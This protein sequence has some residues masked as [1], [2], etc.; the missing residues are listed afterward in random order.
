[1]FMLGFKPGQPMKVE[2]TNRVHIW[3]RMPQFPME[4]WRDKVFEDVAKILGPRFQQ[5]NALDGWKEM[6]NEHG[7]EATP[8]HAPVFSIIR[9]S[10]KETLRNCE[11]DHK[12]ENVKR[13]STQIDQVI[14]TTSRNK[15]SPV[16]DDGTGQCPLGFDEQG[17][18]EVEKENA[19]KG[20]DHGIG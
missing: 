4:M 2:V 9:D 5:I 10:T 14:G 13:D 6:G 3:I 7:G 8:L 12:E 16:E 11:M 18:M 15:Q 19:I 17:Q 20:S 1:M